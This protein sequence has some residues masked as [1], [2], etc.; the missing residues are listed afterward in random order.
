MLPLVL[1]IV[2]TFSIVAYEPETGAMGCAVE[3]RY[4][5]VGA[6]VCWGEAGVGVVATQANVN[7]GYGPKGVALLRE[8][9]SAQQVVDRLLA[10]DTFP[11]KDGRQLAVVDAKGGI[12]V[13]TGSAANAWAGH[14]KGAT[15][16]TQGNI[17]TGVEVVDGMASAFEGA[18]ASLAERLVTALEAG[19]AAGGDRRGQQSAAIL[20][21]QKG[22]GRNIN[23]DV[24]VRL[25]VDD[26]KAP[27]AELRRLLNI[28]LA[29]NEIFKSRTLMT[30][31]KNEE[32]LAWP[33]R[34]SSSGRP[35]P[36]PYLYLGV[37]AYTAG[38]KAEA[39]KALKKG[40]ELN[41]H[42]PRTARCH[43]EVHPAP[44]SRSRVP[45]TSLPRM[46]PALFAVLF[47]QE[48]VSLLEQGKHFLEERNLPAAEKAFRE[49]VAES[50]QDSRA[51]YYLGIALARQDRTEEAIEALENARRLAETSQP[52]DSLR[53]RGGSLEARAL[54][55]GGKGFEAGDGARPDGAG[56]AAPARLGL[57]LE[58]RG[59]ESPGGVRA[60]NRD[61]SLGDGVPVPW[62]RRRS[63]SAGTSPPSPRSG[64]LFGSIPSS[65][66][67]T[68]LSGRS[69]PARAATRRRFRNSLA[70][71]RSMGA[72][73]K[74]ISS[75]A[76]SLF[77][78]ATSTRPRDRSRPRSSH[79]PEHLQAWYNQALVA[80]RLGRERRGSRRVGPGRGASGLGSR[81]PRGEEAHAR[82]VILFVLV[83]FTDVTAQ[84]GI[85]VPPR[86]RRERS[87][88]HGGDLRRRSP[89][90]RLRFRRAPDLLFVNG[91]PLPGTD[92]PRRGN[93]L[94]RNL[95]D[96]TFRD[97]TSEAGLVGE[98][99]GMGG[100]ASDLD[101]DGDIDVLVTAFGEDQL[102]L[103]NG[104]GTFRSRG[105]APA[106]PTVDGP[107]AP[108][109][110]SSTATASST[111]TSPTTSTSPSKTTASA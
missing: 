88:L 44:G 32:A 22:A 53:A 95:G 10:E 31:N 57:L 18:K 16:S 19:Q 78:A 17:L 40:S 37:L 25:H 74:P 96:G 107:R 26:H 51:S 50:P 101:N 87:A 76:S 92:G 65:S 105:R 84:A 41:P 58:S 75:W 72:A 93:A 13:H 97:V 104:D 79:D 83:T 34:P 56:D 46:I 67:P 21:V 89:G 29:M 86:R 66:M 60:G 24:A 48:A 47:V 94:Y 80:E 39:L 61:L 85:L 82:A 36:I 14:K 98:G 70:R 7:V 2:A 81:G 35:R 9:L 27:I 102:Y 5:A 15:Y 52:L 62:T 68:S 49:L 30:E 33:G 99:Y 63:A 4:F 100:A 69:S 109:S 111:C 91:S 71:S 20:V 110:S 6:V 38:D 45:E 106:S 108:P 11:G 90:V 3:S 103:N 28:Q 1:Q 59:G 12:A 73:P 54:A 8:G 23:N 77:A 55:G 64:K 43:P 42:F